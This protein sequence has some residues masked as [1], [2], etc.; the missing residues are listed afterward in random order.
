MFAEWTYMPAIR[1]VPAI[2]VHRWR[3]KPSLANSTKSAKIAASSGV[4][5]RKEGIIV[6]VGQFATI[7]FL[8]SIFISWLGVS[9]KAIVVGS[10]VKRRSSIV[11]PSTR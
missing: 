5:R 9:H 4:A 1:A 8:P 2:F 7:V 6:G 11:S 10:P 3:A